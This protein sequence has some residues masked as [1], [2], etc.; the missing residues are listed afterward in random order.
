[1]LKNLSSNIET[2]E[3]FWKQTYGISLKDY[4]QESG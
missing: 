2:L 3:G 1:M 4:L